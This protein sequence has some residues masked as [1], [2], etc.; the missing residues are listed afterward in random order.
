[1]K[2]ENKRFGD[3]AVFLCASVI[4]SIVCGFL[5][6]R[7]MEL[8]EFEL[9]KVYIIIGLLISVFEILANTNGL[10]YF[11][12]KKG[13]YGLLIGFMLS[14]FLLCA[15]SY[16]PLYSLWMFG[17]AYISKKI[18]P[19]VGVFYQLIFTFMFCSIKEYGVEDFIYY[20]L[21]GSVICVL[22]RFADTIKSLSYIL[23][24]VGS[25]EIIVSF[26][27][28]N[29]VFGHALTSGSLMMVLS[30][31]IVVI[32]SYFV[33][34]SNEA[35]NETMTA[36]METTATL[37]PIEENEK[38]DQIEQ[39][40]TQNRQNENE[41]NDSLL[42]DPNKESKPQRTEM[43]KTDEL[44]QYIT[45][46]APLMRRLN[47]EKPIT[48]RHSLLIG[49]LSEKAAHKINAN[50]RLAR[51]GGLYHEVGKLNGSDYIEEGVC[52][53][54][55]YGLPECIIDIIR[56]HNGKEVHPTSKEAAIVLLTDSIIATIKYF[57]KQP[58][59]KQRSNEKIIDDIFKV[60]LEQGVLNQSGLSLNDYQVLK[61]F[62]RSNLP[63]GG[64]Q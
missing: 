22:I 20:F 45:S 25:V 36:S 42:L 57:E 7:Q 49:I 32:G 11:K 56:Q 44:A 5:I 63:K 13:I 41:S 33:K 60:R 2:A 16:I 23:I 29:F 59:E 8:P 47:E 53:A 21:I 28:S 55:E 17:S 46:D 61:D 39:I 64:N 50:E 43:E 37:E 31:F 58:K 9:L 6:Q 14:S 34:L 24:I 52:L 62:Y 54:T 15:D 4:T 10:P 12:E 40:E 38:T 27:L 3:T 26:L 19:Y 18:H 35:K 1:M 48:Y 30:G 51:A